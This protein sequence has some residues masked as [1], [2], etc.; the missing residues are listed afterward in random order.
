M[1][2]RSGV[3]RAPGMRVYINHLYVHKYA[4]AFACT[5]WFAWIQVLFALRLNSEDKERE[6]ALVSREIA[7]LEMEHRPEVYVR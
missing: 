7:E 1:L 6:R 4:L 3:S 5:T 2:K